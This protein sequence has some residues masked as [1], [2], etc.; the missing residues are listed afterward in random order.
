ME[1]CLIEGTGWREGYRCQA[2]AP[3]NYKH[4]GDQRDA[5]VIHDW[6]H[7]QG[8]GRKYSLPCTCGA[9]DDGS[10]DLA[11]VLLRMDV[12]ANAKK[13]VSG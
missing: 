10:D 12:A 3:E 13:G 8:G 6:A 5:R 11:D 2:F 7:E 9:M 4:P 1:Y